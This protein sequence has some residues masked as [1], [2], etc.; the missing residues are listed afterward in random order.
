METLFREP[1]KYYRT[2]NGQK[3]TTVDKLT[4][5]PEEQQKAFDDFHRRTGFPLPYDANPKQYVGW[6]GRE[7]FR[8]KVLSLNGQFKPLI[9]IG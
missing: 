2:R 6:G 8:G 4:I 9:V 5:T 3:Y 1:E 7:A